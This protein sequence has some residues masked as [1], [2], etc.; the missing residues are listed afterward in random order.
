MCCPEDK[1]VRNGSLLLLCISVL[2]IVC[3]G[4]K[5][6]YALSHL[7]SPK[8]LVFNLCLYV[9]KLILV[10]IGFVDTVFCRLNVDKYQLESQY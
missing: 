5:W 4:D 9:S 8:E 3:L 7:I 10:F 1:L 2:G 6:F